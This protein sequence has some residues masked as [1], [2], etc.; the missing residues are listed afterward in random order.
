MNEIEGR[1][2]QDARLRVGHQPDDLCGIRVSQRAMKEH[3]QQHRKGAQVVQIMD[4]VGRVTVAR[5]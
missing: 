1:I 3:T 5:K 4:P 2:H